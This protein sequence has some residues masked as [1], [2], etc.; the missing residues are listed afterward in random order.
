MTQESV[1][2]QSSS[3]TIPLKGSTLVPELNCVVSFHGRRR[4]GKTSLAQSILRDTVDERTAISIVGVDASYDAFRE[5][6]KQKNVKVYTYDSLEK[7]DYDVFLEE[8]PA[9]WTLP[10]KEIKEQGYSP[11]YVK[12]LKLNEEALNSK[13]FPDQVPKHVLVID[14]TDLKSKDMVWITR[15]FR[16]HRIFIICQD[17]KIPVKLWNILSYTYIMGGYGI[18]QIKT[19][20]KNAPIPN[21]TLEKFYALYGNTTSQPYSFLSIDMRRGFVRDSLLRDY[22]VVG[23]LGGLLWPDSGNVNTIVYPS[24]LVYTYN[25]YA[26]LPGTI[27][28][29]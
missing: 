15:R 2:S 17:T 14:N 18:Q 4:S 16:T 19:V 13:E 27:R 29:T 1:R 5:E 26:N 21:S 6:M 12:T 25:T 8:N 11:N 22:R 28:L 20:Y 24:P 9:L 10:E 3:K 23:A 7:F